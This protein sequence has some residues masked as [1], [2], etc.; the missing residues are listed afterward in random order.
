MLPVWSPNTTKHTDIGYDF[1]D[2]FGG[3]F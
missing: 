1:S 3:D 2:G